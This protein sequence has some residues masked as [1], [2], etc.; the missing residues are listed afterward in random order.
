MKLIIIVVGLL[1]LL[2][3]GGAA[4]YFFLLHDGELDVAE[5]EP[6]RPPVYVDLNEIAVP[7]YGKSRIVSTIRLRVSIQ[8][9][10]EQTRRKAY[11][12][13][14]LFKDAFL[15]DLN[16]GSLRRDEGARV[17]DLASIKRRLKARAE[18]ILGKA[19]VRAILLT[20]AYE[21]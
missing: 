20:Q 14:T 9:N 11:Q 8:V 15:K 18:S 7:Q 12:R 19:N 5:A 21:I 2:G 16:G 13:L 6:E 17:I 3:G 10:D 1:V 4:G